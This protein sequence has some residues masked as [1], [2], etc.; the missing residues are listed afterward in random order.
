MI[1]IC[2]RAAEPKDKT[3]R[4]EVKERREEGEEGEKR[5]GEGEE[6]ALVQCKRNDASFILKI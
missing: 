3:A 5:K 4:L 1:K 6:G 2:I